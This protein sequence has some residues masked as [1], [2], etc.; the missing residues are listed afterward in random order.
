V[1][2]RFWKVARD[3]GMLFVLLRQTILERRCPMRC[4]APDVGF[5]WLLLGLDLL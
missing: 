1:N 5:Y 3:S 2:G 4:C